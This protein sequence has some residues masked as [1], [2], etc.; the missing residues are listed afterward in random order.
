M[1][2]APLEVRGGVDLEE[3]AP[4]SASGA[5]FIPREE[6]DEDDDDDPPPPPP[7]SGFADEE[8]D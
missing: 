2:E 4:G 7:R 8:V 5:G 1:R 6:E 3:A